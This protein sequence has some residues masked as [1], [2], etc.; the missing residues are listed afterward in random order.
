MA[1]ITE[2]EE[3]L[4]GWT[5]LKQ[6]PR[7]L[8]G[9]TLVAGSGI[10]GQILN[11]AAYVNAEKHCRLDITYTTETFDYVPVKTIGL[12]TFRDERYFCRDREKF[13]EMLQQHLQ[14]IL[15]DMKRETEHKE[16]YE[17]EALGFSDWE[18][19]R[20]LPKRIGDYELFITP[21]HPLEYLNGSTIFLDYTDFVHGNQIY[22]SYN[23]FRNDVFAEMKQHYLPLTSNLYDVPNNIPDAKKLK[24]LEALLKKH[25]ECTL[26][27]LAAKD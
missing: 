13:G 9:F 20:S 7:E 26:G 2:E 15:V 10:Q 16:S 24:H 5:L 19:W 17:A 3:G 12:H 1:S 18:Y 11:I 4:K 6:L 27:E 21:E 14:K 25:L 23:A 8:E 22:F